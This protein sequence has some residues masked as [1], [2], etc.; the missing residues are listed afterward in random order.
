MISTILP[1]EVS[2]Y[3]VHGEFES[4]P[5]WP[6]ESVFI[7]GAVE[8]RAK[9]FATGRFCA[10]SALSRLGLPPGPIP[11]GP[12]REP[13]WPVGIAGSIT[14]CKGYC[15][16]AVARIGGIVSIG[17]DA[18]IDEPIP[19]DVLSLISNPS[20]IA[21]INELSAGTHWDKLLFSAKESV[22]KALFPL[23]AQWLDFKDVCIVFAPRD[24]SFL[25]TLPIEATR[26]SSLKTPFIR[27]RYLLDC[28]L[29]VTSVVVFSS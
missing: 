16:A 9:E 26:T 3:E 12:N 29:I 27:G 25:A 15:S 14:H 28:G 10:R 2:S 22:F 13:Q 1:S 4:K 11:V 21:A 5:I 8:K 20:E 7:K 18:E 23:T 24:G 19:A 6:E 17:I